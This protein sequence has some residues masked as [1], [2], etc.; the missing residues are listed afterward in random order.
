MIVSR[1]Y[2]PFV[3]S[4]LATMEQEDSMSDQALQ[5][6]SQVHQP[7]RGTVIEY[8]QQQLQ[9][10]KDMYAKGADD[11]EFGVFVEISQRTGLSIFARQLY[12]ISRWD[13]NLKRMVKSVQ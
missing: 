7:E 8:T 2:A 12:L 5:I 9:L 13:G 4:G 11:A 3:R 6:V 1:G 10:I